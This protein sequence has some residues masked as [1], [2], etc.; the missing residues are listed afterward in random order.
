LAL[1]LPFAF[2]FW[3]THIFPKPLNDKCVN[4]TI[5]PPTPTF[6]YKKYVLDFVNVQ[7]KNRLVSMVSNDQWFFDCS[8]TIGNTDVTGQLIYSFV[9]ILEG[10]TCNNLTE[11]ACIFPDVRG[12]EVKT[13]KSYHL[14]V[15]EK[16]DDVGSNPVLT[17]K[18][19]AP[20]LPNVDYPN[21]LTI[22][23][24]PSFPYTVVADLV[25]PTKTPDNPI[26][27]ELS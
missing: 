8:T 20:P 7:F 24:Q 1:L 16:F 21:A 18:P 11:V 4:P 10:S 26:Y 25:T 5:I 17:I 19:S 27:I 9:A 13:G 12:F 2:F 22:P 6:P 23:P 14:Q 15:L 3:L